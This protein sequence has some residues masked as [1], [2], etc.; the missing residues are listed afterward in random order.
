MRTLAFRLTIPVVDTLSS[1]LSVASSVPSAAAMVIGSVPSVVTSSPETKSTWRANSPGSDAPSHVNDVSDP[2]S[3]AIVFPSPSKSV[4]TMA[5]SPAW[6]A[7]ESWVGVSKA[8]PCRL[9]ATAVAIRAANV[10]GCAS[11]TSSYASSA[12]V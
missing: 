5:G 12:T 3:V 7:S 2:V 6:A 9:C 1:S 8:T 4:Q 10:A 11:Q